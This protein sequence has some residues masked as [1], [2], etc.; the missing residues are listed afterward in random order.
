MDMNDSFN[1]NDGPVEL[2]NPLSVCWAR[3]TCVAGRAS[4]DRSSFRMLEATEVPGIS[5]QATILDL[6]L[7]LAKAE[8]LPLE[9]PLPGSGE[10]QGGCVGKGGEEK[11]EEAGLTCDFFVLRFTK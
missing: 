9:E 3:W 6:R 8:D 10:G 7:K 5:G 4:L 11:R 1:L 2:D